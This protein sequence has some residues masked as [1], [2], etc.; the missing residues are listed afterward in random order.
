M[1]T[2]PCTAGAQIFAKVLQEK[3]ILQVTI[4][5]PTSQPRHVGTCRKQHSGSISYLPGYQHAPALGSSA[6]MAPPAR[7]CFQ[8][9]SH[10][11]ST[12]S[13]LIPHAPSL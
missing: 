7:T 9:S 3:K 11:K 8:V 5:S 12:Q 10:S 2:S 1:L 4:S 13:L 6:N